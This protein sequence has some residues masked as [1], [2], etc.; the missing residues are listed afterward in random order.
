LPGPQSTRARFPARVPENLAAIAFK[1]AEAA[2]SMSKREGVE[3]RSVVKRSIS[4]ISAAE[5]T[6]CM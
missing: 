6:I 4:R 1:T 5:T 2:A 3:Y